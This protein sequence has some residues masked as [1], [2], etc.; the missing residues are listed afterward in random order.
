MYRI[1]GKKAVYSYGDAFSLHKRQYKKDLYLSLMDLDAGYS[2]E[3]MLMILQARLE[4]V[5]LRGSAINN[6]HI[7]KSYFKGWKR[8]DRDHAETLREMVRREL[9][10]S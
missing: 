1:C 10:M 5:C 6:P 2:P 4:Y 3:R 7:P 9:A 8:I